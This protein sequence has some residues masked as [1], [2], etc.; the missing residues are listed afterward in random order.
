MNQGAKKAFK[1][2]FHSSTHKQGYRG[3]TAAEGL[4]Y[5]FYFRNKHFSQALC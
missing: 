4:I 3:L 1:L 2:L 5:L